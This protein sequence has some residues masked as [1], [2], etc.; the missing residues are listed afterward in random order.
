M[1]VSAVAV[2]VLVL[3]TFCKKDRE[4]PLE[5]RTIDKCFFFLEIMEGFVVRRL[6][7]SFF[8]KTLNNTAFY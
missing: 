8:L 3:V 4:K 1:A 5:T 7:H 2:G 6:V